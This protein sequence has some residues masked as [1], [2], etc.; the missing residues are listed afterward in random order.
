MLNIED[1][2]KELHTDFN[3]VSVAEKDFFKR[4][5]EKTIRLSSAEKEV[6]KACNL[7]GPLEDGDIPSK[8][9]RD[10][11]IDD[12]FIVSVVVKGQEGYNACTLSGHLATLIDGVIVKS[13]F[14]KS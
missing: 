4:V 1:I 12:G 8:S 9:A 5:F 6:L 2:A 7:K 11:L 3:L 13:E 10:S 14:E